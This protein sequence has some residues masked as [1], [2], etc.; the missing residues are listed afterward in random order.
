MKRNK[1]APGKSSSYP[2]PMLI[3]TDGENNINNNNKDF[4]DGDD[5]E[6]SLNGQNSS[7][8]PNNNNNNH[9]PKDDLITFKNYLNISRSVSSILA[10][11]VSCE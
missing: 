1:Q 6:C 7:M 2:Q 9:K 10:H 3:D 8:N 11:Q 4:I 5:D